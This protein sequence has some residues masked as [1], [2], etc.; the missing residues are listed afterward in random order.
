MS[1][2]DDFRFYRKVYAVVFLVFG[3]GELCSGANTNAILLW[4]LARLLWI[5]G[6][7]K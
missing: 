4:I 5:D 2:S 7:A 3:I 6:G 1:L